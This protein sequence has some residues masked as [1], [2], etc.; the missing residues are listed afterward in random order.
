MKRLMLLTVAVV[1]L[2]V[3]ALGCTAISSAAGGN[4]GMANDTWY[5]TMVGIPAPLNVYW[6][7]KVFYCPPMSASQSTCTEAEMI[8]GS[9]PSDAAVAA[10][11]AD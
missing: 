3:A 5:T 1:G 10:D 6:A 7:T 8:E 2:T 11:N 4:S 9:G